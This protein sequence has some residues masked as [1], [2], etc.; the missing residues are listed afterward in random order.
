MSVDTPADRLD[1]ATDPPGVAEQPSVRGSM[2]ALRGNG[3]FRRMWVGQAISE[4][5]SSISMLAFPLLA[6]AMTGSALNAGL[7][8][9]VG[10]LASLAGQVP[11]GHLAD[12]VDKRTLLIGSDLIR[13]G[14]LFT[15][16]AMAV[17]GWYR[18]EA[19]VGLTALNMVAAAIVGPAETATMRAVV[20]DRELAEAS[21]LVQGRSYAITLATPT[22][23]G[24]LFALSRAL[25][26]LTDGLSFLFSAV[27]TARIR[28][29]L[30][31][32]PAAER[33]RFTPSFARG[34]T[35]LWRTRMLRW[36][37]LFGTSTN[38]AVSVLIYSVL[39]GSGG[40]GGVA[41]GLG[42]TITAAGLAGLLGSVAGPIV[43]RKLLLHQVLI[44]SCLVRAVAVLPAV[45]LPGPVT[46]SLAMVIVMFTSPI[47]AAATGTARMLA[48][49]RPVL[50]TVSGATGLLATCA[51]PLAPI[52]AGV[53]L[54]LASGSVTFGILGGCF[55]LMAIGVALP[56]SLRVKASA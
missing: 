40:S 24:F 12:T 19:M 48:I 28:A 2:L 52:L 31:P 36:A 10:F 50:G 14:C 3:D 39:L 23:G 27:C 33:V 45:L 6:L 51:Q 47:A 41:T 5:G 37:T 16:T 4:A 21:A 7:I 43:Q 53:L 54:Q 38:L 32:D 34:W 13:A 46:R 49:P 11:A 35:I 18:S 44:C 30:K 1:P 29:C 42:L 8:A 56:P 17:T 25:P 20:S 9:T 55:L 26:F 22:V 15:V